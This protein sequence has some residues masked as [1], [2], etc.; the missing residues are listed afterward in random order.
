[1]SIIQTMQKKSKAPQKMI[2]HIG[3]YLLPIGRLRKDTGNGYR[4][5]DRA[6]ND[7]EAS[8][9]V[10]RAPTTFRQSA[11]SLQGPLAAALGR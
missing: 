4:T 10:R 1:M 3:Q 9:S 5:R 7:K 2:S 11:G 6:K 8:L